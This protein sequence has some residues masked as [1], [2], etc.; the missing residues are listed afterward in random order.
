MQN[1]QFAGCPSAATPGQD[2]LSRKMLPTI[3]V[4]SVGRDRAWL[5]A[6]LAEAA[7]EN[8]GDI[9]IISPIGAK[10]LIEPGIITVDDDQLRSHLAEHLSFARPSPHTQARSQSPLS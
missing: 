10:R 3:R 4:T 7:I 8:H 5:V 2:G 6:T 9:L 1:V